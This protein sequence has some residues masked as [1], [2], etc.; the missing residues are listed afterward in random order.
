[1]KDVITGVNDF[2]KVLDEAMKIAKFCRRGRV[3]STIKERQKEEL[4][5]TVAIQLWVQTRWQTIVQCLESLIASKASIQQSCFV[6]SLTKK[7][8]TEKGKIIK[9]LI[10]NESVWE[11]IKTALKYIK[12]IVAT[13]VAYER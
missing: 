5:K 8:N 9:A 11:G 3:Y 4:G 1:V 7:W 13:L 6:A 10:Q 12:P 2:Q